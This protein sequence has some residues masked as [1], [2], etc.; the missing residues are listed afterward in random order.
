MLESTEYKDITTQIC[1]TRKV[2]NG[3]EN[4][5][6]ILIQAIAINILTYI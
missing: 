3:H 2:N 4:L 1:I 6:A 5:P